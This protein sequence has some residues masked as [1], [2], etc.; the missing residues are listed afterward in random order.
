MNLGHHKI[1][2]GK[3]NEPNGFSSSYIFIPELPFAPE[4]L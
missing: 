1:H 3:D 4:E 2:Q